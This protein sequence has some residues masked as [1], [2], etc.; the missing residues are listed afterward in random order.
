MGAGSSRSGALLAVVGGERETL[1]EFLETLR[2]GAGVDAATFL[3]DEQRRQASPELLAAMACA[4]IEHRA[5]EAASSND[6]EATVAFGGAARSVSQWLTVFPKLAKKPECVVEVVA[7]DFLARRQSGAAADPRDYIEQFPELAESISTRLSQLDPQATLPAQQP[8]PDAEAA[9]DTL[10]VAR[11]V[12]LSTK[13][14]EGSSFGRRVRTA[15]LAPHA[16]FGDYIL[17]Q[18]IARGGMGVVYKAVQRRLNRTVAVKMILSGNLASEQEVRRFYT[19]AEAAAH[20]DHPGI[21]PIY[22]V[23]E[24][25]GQ[26]FF[27]MGYV[28]GESLQQR[29]KSG[30]L[31]PREAAEIVCHVA[32]AIA[33]AH[34]QGV[35][36][37]DLKPSNILLT[38][39]GRPRVTDFG[40][41]KTV[42]GD[43]GLTASGQILGTPGYMPPE[44]AMGDIHQIGPHSDVYSLGAVL[45]CLLTGRP[46]FQAATAVE[47]LHQVIEREPARP[48]LLNPAV[49]LDLETICLKCLEKQT[50]H[51]I[52][53]AGELAAELNRYL[54][55]EPIRSRR[56]GYVARARRWLRRNR[57]TAALVGLAPVVIVAVAA[58]VVFARWASESRELSQARSAFEAGLDQ[59]ELTRTYL[60]E[61][62]TLIARI[63]ER[64]PAEAAKFQGRLKDAWTAETEGAIRRPYLTDEHVEQIETALALLEQEGSDHASRLRAL[65]DQRRTAW[66]EAFQLQAPFSNLSAVFAPDKAALQGGKLYPAPQ[67]QAASSNGS[68]KQ[69]APTPVVPTQVAAGPRVLL[70]AE[71]DAGWEQG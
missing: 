40:L 6:P 33:Y 68:Q 29:L 49:D 67:Q 18:E 7:A 71:F 53:S 58:A 12:D 30:P 43:S 47:T 50:S 23:N 13:P 66:Q 37:R 44:Q 25:E 32:E 17:E 11:S 51:R 31:P 57:T 3:S 45:Y 48:R 21:V 69:V 9:P 63:E 34:T 16:E 8:A 24:V 10:S 59:V 4:E 20:L 19:E 14:P 64:D 61:M 28:D 1:A 52:E 2:Q 56:V 54:Q 42:E 35:V 27:S 65:L 46:P 22:E 5:R 41:A 39:E 26:H 38:R 62:K 60:D 36:H 70:R 15:Q 55:G